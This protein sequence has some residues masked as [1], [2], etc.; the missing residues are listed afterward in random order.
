MC[1]SQVR[2]SKQQPTVDMDT[3]VYF[4]TKEIR[5][6]MPLCFFT[7]SFVPLPWCCLLSGSVLLLCME[8]AA[9]AGSSG[10][11]LCQFLLLAV[12]S[13]RCYWPRMLGFQVFPGIHIHASLI[14]RILHHFQVFPPAKIITFFFPH[15][16]PSRVTFWEP[17]Y[18]IQNPKPPFIPSPNSLCAEAQCVVILL[19]SSSVLNLYL[20]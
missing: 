9:G 11:N 4:R 19:S 18:S 7:Q 12:T 1:V 17:L 3:E 6:F 2:Q 10:R 5:H 8:I 15:S 14:S 13:R 16:I 20:L